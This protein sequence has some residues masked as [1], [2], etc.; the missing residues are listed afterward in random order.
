MIVKFNEWQSW[1]DENN[2][3][4]KNDFLI[5]VEDCFVDFMDKGAQV[6]QR[7]SYGEQYPGIRYIK[8]PETPGDETLEDCLKSSKI[9]NDFYLDIENCIDKVKLKYN[10]DVEFSNKSGIDNNLITLYF[11]LKNKIK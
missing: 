9:I 8:L 5:Y 2:V 11:P 6:V 7:N 1:R 3:D 4:G 10:I